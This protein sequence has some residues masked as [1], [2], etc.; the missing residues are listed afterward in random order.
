MTTTDISPGPSTQLLELSSGHVLS[1]ALHVVAELGVADVLGDEPLSAA[2][3]A[4]AGGWDADA[5]HRVLRLLESHGVFRLDDRGRWRH[6]SRSRRLRTDDPASQRGFVRMNGTPFG[7][8]S[9]TALQHSIE[10]GRPGISRLHPRGPWAYLEAHPDQ[11]AVFQQA[12]ADKGRA[13]VAAAMAAHDFGRHRRVVDV[14]GGSG[15]LVQAVVE[16][17]PQVEGVLFELPAVVQTLP[18]RDGIDVVPGDFFRDALPAGDCYVLMN[19]V[20]DWDDDEAAAI[21]RAVAAAGRPQRATVLLLE[22]VLPEGPDGHWAKTLDV[23]MLALTGGR[24]RTRP[25]YDALL[26]EAGLILRRVTST[27]TAFSVIEAATR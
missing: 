3:L 25:Q 13:D 14:A 4:E 21:L 22:A 16:A 6:T 18:P 12:M 11:A 20:H 2:D 7:W 17:H 9:F 1:R 19:I 23:M 27:D 10:T 24:E 15:H 5:L 8:E 26:R